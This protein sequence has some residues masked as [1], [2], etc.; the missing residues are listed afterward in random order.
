[1][2]IILVFNF[3]NFLN[4]NMSSEGSDFELKSGPS[5]SPVVTH[6]L[7]LRKF[8]IDGNNNTNNNTTNNNNN[9]DDDDGSIARF[10]NLNYLINMPSHQ[11]DRPMTD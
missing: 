8:N 1:M 7:K 5:V 10:Q 4:L 2:N 11:L 9:D 3:I 6:S